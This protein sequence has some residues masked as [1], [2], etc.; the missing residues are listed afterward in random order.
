MS[1]LVKYFS[2]IL[3]QFLNMIIKLTLLNRKND[4]TTN[5]K[6]KTI[7]SFERKDKKVSRMDYNSNNVYSHRSATYVEKT[8]K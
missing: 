4:I 3:K 5:K 8:K 1:T 6:Q 2:L 7:S